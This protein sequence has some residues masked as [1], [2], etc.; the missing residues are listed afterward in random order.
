MCLCRN[1]TFVFGAEGCRVDREQRKQL[2][3]GFSFP[4]HFHSLQDPSLLSKG[5][6]VLFFTGSHE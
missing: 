4:P 1:L 5:F 3:F 2:G 6:P